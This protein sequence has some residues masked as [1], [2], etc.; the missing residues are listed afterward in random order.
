[1]I[2]GLIFSAIWH[3]V[4]AILLVIVIFGIIV[5]LTST[6]PQDNR[7][8]SPP[9]EPDKSHFNNSHFNDTPPPTVN[10][11]KKNFGKLDN[12]RIAPEK[13]DKNLDLL[14]LSAIQKPSRVPSCN[15]RG[16]NGRK[17]ILYFSQSQAQNVAN[18]RSKR[19]GKKLSVYPCPSQNGFHLTSHPF[20]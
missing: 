11:L 13:L 5:I 15:C 9:K 7:P 6:Q 1:M 12:T 3:A 4:P 8:I 17:K 2:S 20:S 18:Y 19:T 16:R 10:D 14:D